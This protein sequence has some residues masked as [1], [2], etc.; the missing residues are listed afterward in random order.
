MRLYAKAVNN[1]ARDIVKALMD[2]GDIEVP[3]TRVHE[4]EQDLAAIMKQY[5]ADEEQ[6]N[7][8]A[9]EALERRGMD[10]SQ[11]ARVRREMAEQ[12][13]HRLGDEGIDYIIDQMLEFLLISRNIDEVYADDPTMRKKIYRILKKHLAVEEEID[14]EVRARL[15]H[16][17][18]GTTQWEVEYRKQVE[19]MK[20]LKGLI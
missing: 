5:L 16:L 3:A 17:Q 4:A 1:I 13:G 7:R 14:R 12:H 18:E 11:Y 19:Q 9:R 15:K 2:D 8:A 10:Q 20:R 6:V